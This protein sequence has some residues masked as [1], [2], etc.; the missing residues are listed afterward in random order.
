M[1][2]VMLFNPT[3]KNIKIISWRSVLL[4][5]ETG[6]PGENRHIVASLWHNIVRFVFLIFLGSCCSIY[7]LWGFMLLNLFF[8]GVRVAHDF[9]LVF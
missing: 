7:F 2:E 8:V 9:I 3:F 4:V 1:K 6:V 5:D